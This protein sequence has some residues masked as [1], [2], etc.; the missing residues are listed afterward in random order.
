MSENKINSYEVKNSLTYCACCDKNVK[1]FLIDGFCLFSKN[2][3]KE[4]FLEN[5][6][7]QCT[8]CQNFVKTHV[9]RK[10]KFAPLGPICSKK[11]RKKQ[12]I[13]RNRIRN[14]LHKKKEIVDAD[15]KLY[16]WLSKKAHIGDFRIEWIFNEED[17][18]KVSS[19]LDLLKGR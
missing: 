15:I 12:E 13:I 18:K 1:S 17:F 16:K 5:Y 4:R 3:N 11:M 8:L 2:K 7:L 9:V 14:I 6:F 10:N 19:L